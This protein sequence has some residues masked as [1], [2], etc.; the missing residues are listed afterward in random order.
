MGTPE[1]CLS[2]LGVK[3]TMEKAGQV[4]LGAL[5]LVLLN[6]SF[7][8]SCLPSTGPRSHL[9]LFSSD[10]LAILSLNQLWTNDADF[11]RYSLV[12]VN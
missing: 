12:P 10:F 5:L 11:E 1:Y 4:T 2:L 6:H 3:L 9:L 8:H 7:R